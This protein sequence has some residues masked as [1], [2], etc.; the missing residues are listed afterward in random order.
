MLM[1]IYCFVIY[2]FCNIVIYSV[3]LLSVLSVILLSM[4]MILLSILIVIRHLICGNNLYLLLNLNLICE[5]LSTGARSGLLI[6]MLGKL[7][8]FRLIG[9]ITLVL[10]L[11]KWMGLFLKKNYLLR[12]WGW[13]SLVNWI[14]ALT[15]SLL[16]KRPPRKLEPWFVLWSFFLLR[17]LCISM[18]LPYGYVWNT[19]ALSWMV[20][21]VTTWNCWLSYRNEYAVLLVLHLNHWLI[22]EG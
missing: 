7:N 1:I 15:L 16:L 20:F 11:L 10:L 9:Q 22:V 17:L 4:L 14:G 13:L 3:I 2:R 18:N 21:L 8:W 5:T 19:V 6:L 12:C